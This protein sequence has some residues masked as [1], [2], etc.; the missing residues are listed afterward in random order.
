MSCDDIVIVETAT[1]CQNVLCSMWV[2][3]VQYP[4]IGYK[5][6]MVDPWGLFQFVSRSVFHSFIEKMAFT[7]LLKLSCSCRLCNLLLRPAQGWGWQQRR[8]RRWGQQQAASVHCL[9]ATS[10]P[11]L[12]VQLSASHW[13]ATPAVQTHLVDPAGCCCQRSERRRRRTGKEPLG[14]FELQLIM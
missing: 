1:I 6:C 4:I 10:L 14:G 9:P 3:I 2:L 8:R 5:I 12:A 11:W 13:P 7:L